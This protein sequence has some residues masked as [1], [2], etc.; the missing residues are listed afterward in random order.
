[1]LLRKPAASELSAEPILSAAENYSGEM[2]AIDTGVRVDAVEFARGRV[3]LGRLLAKRGIGYGDRVVMAVANGPLFAAALCAV[4]ARGASPLIL[5]AKTPA[6]EMRRYAERYAARMVFGDGSSET[7]YRETGLEPYL[8]EAADWARLLCANV[9]IVDESAGNVSLVL[10]GVPLHPTSG[11]TGQPKVALRPGRPAIAEAAHY[12]ETTGI[13]ASDTILVAAPQSHAYCYGMGTMV[14]LLC[15]ASI[16]TMRGFEAGLVQSALRDTNVTVVPAVPAMLGSL[17]FGTR[18]DLFARVNTVFSA[19]APLNE[20]T[21]KAFANKFGIAVRPLYG[22]TETGGIAISLPGSQAVAGICVGP[23]MK[24]VEVDVR[25]DGQGLAP[26]LGMTYVRSESMMTGYLDEN[27]LDQSFVVDGWFK[28]GD[29]ANQDTEGRI[30]LHGRQS[31]VINVAG[32]KVIPSEVENVLLR[33]SGVIEAKVYSREHRT[34]SQSVQA[35]VVA[36]GVDDAD[37]RAHCEKNLVYYKRPSMISFVEALPRNA[38]GKID[39]AAL[40]NL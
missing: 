28:T 16:I 30:Y 34:G 7:E 38:T 12:I 3:A 5:H 29:I 1:M 13:Q 8:V 31:E 15:G 21:A 39:M 2:H 40:S 19:G 24:D 26:G 25:D 33:I 6:A 22:T 17:M 4:L 11:T 9:K 18:G 37:V 35:A 27:G 36:H 20:K 14:P 10:P 23:A 32:M